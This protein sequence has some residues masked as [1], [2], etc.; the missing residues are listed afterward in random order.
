MSEA[1]KPKATI[2][3]LDALMDVKMNDI[4]TLPDYITP[5]PGAYV[6][7]IKDCTFDKYDV[8]DDNKKP[9]G[10]KGTRIKIV[11]SVVETVALEAGHEP[12]PNGSLFSESFQGSEEGIKYFKKAAMNILGVTDFEGASL[13]DVKNE[14]PGAEFKAKITIRATKG[15]AGKVYENLTIRAANPVVAE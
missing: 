4:E 9:T 13:G 8:K 2:L 11:Y 6:L 12:V 1:L 15:E 5:P 3:D 10:Q 7:A 14:L